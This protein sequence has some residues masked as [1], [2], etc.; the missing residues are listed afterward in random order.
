MAKKSKAKAS[1]PKKTPKRYRESRRDK[2]LREFRIT[3]AMAQK[4]LKAMNASGLREFNMQFI[5]K[6]DT[7]LAD[8]KYG[9]KHGYWR[10]NATSMNMKDLMKYT[11]LLAQFNT[12][13]YNTTQY[14]EKYVEDLKERVGLDDNN[15]L[16]DTFR[17]FRE[18]GF[19]G[20]YDSTEMLNEIAIW[21]NTT[22]RSGEDLGD[23]IDALIDA[24]NENAPAEA[25]PLTT[26]D[27]KDAIKNYNN[28]VDI[29]NNPT[30]YGKETTPEELAEYQRQVFYAQWEDIL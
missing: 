1:K 4:K 10:Q 21:Y 25:N 29:W 17:I 26:D 30:T 24:Y 8:P 13:E 27:I 14:T 9:T 11:A 19:A 16:K 7:I 20:R 3:H 2:L 18:Y 5:R 6:W 12:S 23:W 15:R 28:N 22:G